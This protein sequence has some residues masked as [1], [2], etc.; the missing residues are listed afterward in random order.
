M[1]KNLVDHFVE[2]RQYLRNGY[3]LIER[4]D[5]VS[6]ALGIRSEGV[7]KS[8]KAWSRWKNK[9]WTFYSM[10]PRAD[11]SRHLTIYR[12]AQKSGRRGSVMANITGDPFRGWDPFRSWGP[13]LANDMSEV[14][15]AVLSLYERVSGP[16]DP[17]ILT[18]KPASQLHAL[19]YPFLA[20]TADFDARKLTRQPVTGLNTALRQTTAKGFAEAAF[21]KRL[22]RKDLVKACAIA[23]LD[24]VRV[25]AQ[26]RRLVPVDWLVELLNL[27]EDVRRQNSDRAPADIAALLALVPMTS[28]R[29]L[30]VSEDITKNSYNVID[31][32]RALTNI[33]AARG[34]GDDTWITPEVSGAR[35]WRQLHD[36]L[37][38]VQR[39]IENVSLPIDQDSVYEALDG[40]TA[41]DGRLRIASAKFTDEL[42]AWGDEMHNCIS[43]Y[44]TQALAHRT[45]LFALFDGSDLIA[46]IEID[47]SGEIRQL[48][49]K[50]NRSL[51]DE[52][53]APVRAAI[54]RA[55]AAAAR[56]AAAIAADIASGRE[57]IAA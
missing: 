35:T 37:N 48:H 42:E 34:P 38:G 27:P 47:K 46:N 17:R 22:V 9:E 57:L 14:L 36:A 16:I 55:Q 13:H 43:G 18:L 21:G 45:Y 1:E 33:R 30:L 50:F 39:R 40:V 52:L 11:G 7:A 51:P 41:L 12:R 24:H 3:M 20:L 8:G 19:A 31:S 44:R 28:R 15:A 49:G 4:Y 56:K 10:K 2:R 5:S 29:R 6:V 23:P 53:D 25:A 26:V 54:R 32:G